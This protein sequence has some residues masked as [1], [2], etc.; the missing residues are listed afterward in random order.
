MRKGLFVSHGSSW[1]NSQDNNLASKM[2]CSDMT[3]PVLVKSALG[4]SNWTLQCNAHLSLDVI[5]QPGLSTETSKSFLHPQHQ[6]LLGRTTQ[7]ELRLSGFCLVVG[8][9]SCIPMGSGSLAIIGGASTAG[10]SKRLHFSVWLP[11]WP[12]LSSLMIFLATTSAA[13]TQT[14][15]PG[16]DSSCPDFRH[17]LVG[18]DAHYTWKYQASAPSDLIALS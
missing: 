2:L 7:R 8:R 13:V 18:F 6:T 5:Y 15:H 12:F 17:I 11:E 1:G 16:H 14:H 3:Q 10:I 9:N 4:S